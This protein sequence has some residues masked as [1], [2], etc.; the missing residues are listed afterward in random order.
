MYFW[1][2]KKRRG[3]NFTW[4]SRGGR[5]CDLRK[6]VEVQKR[7]KLGRLAKM[8]EGG[9]AAAKMTS[10]RNESPVLKKK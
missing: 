3:R 8:G 6:T 7:K 2:K 10:E 5:P 4:T 1:E 9:R